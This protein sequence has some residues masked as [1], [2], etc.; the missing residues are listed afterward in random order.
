MPKWLKF[1]LL[2]LGIGIVGFGLL[3]GGFVWWVSANKERLADT[4]R[5]AQAEGAT[6][7]STHTQ[8]E[9]VDDALAQMKTC[10]AIDF[11]C[12]AGNKIR[13]T[14]CIPAASEDTTCRNIPSKSEIFKMAMWANEECDRRGFHGS[15]PCGRLM[16][17][18][19]DA[20]SRPRR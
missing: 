16:Q 4:G 1:V 14:S 19:V 8:N 6:F 11:V 3:I 9:C 13:L 15:Q 20:C 18:I 17:G 5:N 2:F 10:G 7:G 12:E